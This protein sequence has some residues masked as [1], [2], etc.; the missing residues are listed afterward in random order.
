MKNLQRLHIFK[1]EKYLALLQVYFFKYHILGANKSNN[2]RH[3]IQR[4]FMIEFIVFGL[5]PVRP[6]CV[7]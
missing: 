5:M 4:L 3:C 2:I 1:I 6:I 7:I